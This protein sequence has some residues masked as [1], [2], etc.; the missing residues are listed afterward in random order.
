VRYRIGKAALYPTTPIS[1]GESPATSGGLMISLSS[2][3]VDVDAVA[4]EQPVLTHAKDLA[5][6]CGARLKIVDVLPFVPPSARHFVTAGLEQELVEHRVQRL[7][8]L[9]GEVHGVEVTTELL[10]GRPATALIQE[11]LAAGHG[12]VVRSHDR[13]RADSPRQYGAVD[14]ELLRACPCPVWLIG[15]RPASHAPW[16]VAA[17]INPNPDDATEQ[18]LN[19]TVLEWAL[20]LKHVTG[21]DLALLHAWTPFGAS[22]LRSHV[23]EHEFVEYIDAARRTAEDTMQAFTKAHADRLHGVRVQLVQGEP[24]RAIPQFID[25]NGIDLVVMGTVARSGVRGLV[26]GNTAERVL[27]R[28]RGSVIAVKPPGF[29]SPV[30][31][32]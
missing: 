32:T 21:A 30:E 27:Q 7:Q 1:V 8:T 17:A 29:I 19:E 10:R 24:E 16:R 18:Q 6:R 11:V 14:M 25:T 5:A 2:V 12:L 28:L 3:L 13:D 26:M 20:M 15:P 22:V 31:R 9:G 4:A 23:P